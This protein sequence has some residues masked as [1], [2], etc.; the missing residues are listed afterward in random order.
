MRKKL[1]FSKVLTA[2]RAPGRKRNALTQVSPQHFI[3][4][5]NKLD[6][7]RSP[8]PAIYGILDVVSLALCTKVSNK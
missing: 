1:H 7:A 6:T 4:S 8:V 2:L 5:N 3:D